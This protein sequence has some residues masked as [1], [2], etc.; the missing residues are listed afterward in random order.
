MS[1]E[2]LAIEWIECWTANRLDMGSITRIK[3][4]KFTSASK[5]VKPI[6]T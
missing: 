4:K 1:Y 5:K 2:A 6:R 3:K